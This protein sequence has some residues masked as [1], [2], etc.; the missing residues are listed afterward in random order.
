MLPAAC[1][2]LPA[3]PPAC[4]LLGIFV[5]PICCSAVSELVQGNSFPVLLP[6]HPLSIVHPLESFEKKLDLEI[7]LCHLEEYDP[8]DPCRIQGSD[9]P[10]PMFLTSY[11]SHGIVCLELLNVFCYYKLLSHWKCC[12]L[13]HQ[14]SQVKSPSLP[15]LFLFNDFPQ[16]MGM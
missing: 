11:T 6:P 1:I 15:C 5:L 8:L 10:L 3:C 2:C 4:C 16:V 13:Y 7:G 14:P 12:F 9:A